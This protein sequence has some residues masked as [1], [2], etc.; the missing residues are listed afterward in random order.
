MVQ[1]IIFFYIYYSQAFA[2][3]L[4]L[5]FTLP[6]WNREMKVL[7][8]FFFVLPCTVSTRSEYP[9]GNLDQTASF[10][11]MVM[12]SQFT[13]VFWWLLCHTTKKFVYVGAYT[14]FMKNNCKIPATK[15]STQ[16]RTS[17]FHWYNTFLVILFFICMFYI[18]LLKVWPYII[19]KFYPSKFMYHLENCEKNAFRVVWHHTA[20]NMRCVPKHR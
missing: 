4:L 16:F 14:A 15:V 17:C 2:G 9:K 3:I 6:Y 13:I 12:V 20:K 5:I 8:I 7:L 18:H 11:A 10:L 19:I 1:F